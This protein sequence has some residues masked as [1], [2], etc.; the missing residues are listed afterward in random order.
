MPARPR[1]R[2]PD[3]ARS[4]PSACSHLGGHSTRRAYGGEPHEPAG[5]PPPGGRPRR[6]G[7]AARASTTPRRCSRSRRVPPRARRCGGRRDASGRSSPPRSRRPGPEGARRDRDGRPGRAPV[8]RLSSPAPMPPQ[9][10][11]TCASR[12]LRSASCSLV[13][14]S[15]EF[16][17]PW[18]YPPERPDQFEELLLRS[19]REDF[20]CFVVHRRR[21]GRRSRACSTSPRSCAGSSSRRSSATTARRARRQRLMRE[22]LA[23]VRSTRSA[24][25]RCTASRPTSSPATPRSIAL[26][27]GAGFRLEGYSPRY[28]LIGGR[29]RD[30]ERYA[31][32]VD[33]RAKRRRRELAA[34]GHRLRR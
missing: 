22:G 15:R 28:L 27:R 23:L 20:A 21:V 12:P 11:S 7:R 33:E 13:R 26:A 2:G 31:L 19:R 16:H 6:R 9:P 25:S 17:R 32:T 14:A 34:S 29:W 8:T 3:A 1:R 18:A 30:H 24:R 5:R 10:A 4:R